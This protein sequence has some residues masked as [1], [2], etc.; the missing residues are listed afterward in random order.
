M[1]RSAVRRFPPLRK[2]NERLTHLESTV[3]RLGFILSAFRI[4]AGYR[5]N[6]ATL[7]RPMGFA[8]HGDLET[9]DPFFAQRSAGH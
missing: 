8:G 5:G 6:E 7:L 2:S 4:G 1:S 3:H 9:N